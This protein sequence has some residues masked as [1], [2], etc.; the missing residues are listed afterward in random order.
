MASFSFDKSRFYY[1]DDDDDT[2]LTP[3]VDQ[4]SVQGLVGMMR[5]PVEGQV[6]RTA[7]GVGCGFRV[8]LTMR[9]GK[10]TDKILAQ[11]TGIF[12]LHRTDAGDVH[13]IPVVLARVD[14]AAPVDGAATI[15]A[16][17]AQWSNTDGDLPVV[18]AAIAP[19]ASAAVSNTTQTYVRSP[20]AS[21]KRIGATAAVPTGGVG[22]AGKP[23]L[24]EGVS[25]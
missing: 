18:G 17:F 9:L 23:Q 10:E 11:Q 7:D 6:N 22:V 8:T 3:A 14:D 20:G 25:P 19:A 16:T 12:M 5:L 13:A 15:R 24:A 1:G 21:I 4:V 2:D